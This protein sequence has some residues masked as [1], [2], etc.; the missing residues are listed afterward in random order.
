MKKLLVMLAALFVTTASAEPATPFGFVMGSP[1]K[2]IDPKATKISDN[3]QY[4]VDP[5]KDFKGFDT[6]IVQATPRAG[7]CWLMVAT[8]PI[9][10]ANGRGE[11]LVEAYFKFVE[12]STKNFGKP[13]DVVLL[14]TED[15]P[16]QQP[17]QFMLSLLLQDRTIYTMWDVKQGATL[18]DN[19]TRVAVHMTAP[20]DSTSGRIALEFG[21]KNEPACDLEVLD[22]HSQLN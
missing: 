16:F 21:F 13:S 7:L 18:P 8:T 19:I 22:Q 4:L 5:S 6:F 3:Y 14:E 12:V 1:I 10:V 9:G 15:N 20:D 17:H 2:E 11:A